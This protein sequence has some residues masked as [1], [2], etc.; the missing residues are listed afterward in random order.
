MDRRFD[1][2]KISYEKALEVAKAK[3]F[4][5]WVVAAKR[6]IATV[7]C[8]KKEYERCETLMT[9]NFELCLSRP[10]CSSDILEIPLNDLNYHYVFEIRD[11]E[12]PR[13]FVT[14]F[15]STKAKFGKEEYRSVACDYAKIFV[16]AGHRELALQLSE[17]VKCQQDPG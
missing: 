12:K 1:E 11:K 4:I 3:E 5:G 15:R 8:N 9:E 10:D 6:G 7:Y 16:E 14:L 2:A 17:E 13:K